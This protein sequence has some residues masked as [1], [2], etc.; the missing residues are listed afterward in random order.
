[1]RVDLLFWFC[2]WL[3]CRGKPCY[4]RIKCRLFN[5]YFVKTY[6]VLFYLLGSDCNV[7]FIH[8]VKSIRCVIFIY[9]VRLP[10]SAG[11]KYATRLWWTL[12][13]EKTVILP[14]SW[15]FNFFCLLES[16]FMTQSSRFRL[17]SLFKRAWNQFMCDFKILWF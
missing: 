3:L 2:W 15:L 12:N 10:L 7:F 9:Q 13:I 5:W 17:A 1:M 4:T 6:N 8:V 16:W 11:L 14:R